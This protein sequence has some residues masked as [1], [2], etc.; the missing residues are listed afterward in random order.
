V[1]S[2][3]F[4][5][6]FSA[7]TGHKPYDYQRRLAGGD[8]GRTAESLL[9]SIPTGLGKTA[10]VVLAWLWNRVALL[11]QAEHGRWPRRLVYCLPMRTLVEQTRDNVAEWLARLAFAADAD[12]PRVKAA[13]E[14]LEE[15]ARKR[16]LADEGKLR[17]LKQDLLTAREDLIWLLEHSPVVLMGGEEIDARK[18]EWDI[19]PERPAILIGTQDM[20]LSRALNRGYAMNRYRW[21]MQFG[22]LNNDCLWV[23]DEIQLMGPGL[24][25]G[26]QLEAFREALGGFAAPTDAR[27]PTA[28][29]SWYASATASRELVI[30]RDWRSADGDK[31]PPSDEFVVQ[32]GVADLGDRNGSLGRRRLAMKAVEV[33]DGWYFDDGE[34]PRRIVNEH[35]RMLAETA[36]AT[37]VRR[38][39]LVVC[40]TVRKART[41]F[42]ALDKELAGVSDRPELLLLHSRFRRE[43][44][45]AIFKRIENP[46]DNPMGQIVVATQVIEA[47]VDISSAALWTEA[48]PLPSIVQRFGRLNRAGEFGHDGKLETGWTPRAVVVGVG[49]KLAPAGRREKAD[50]A[51]KR[52]KENAT[53]FRPYERSEC[54]SSLV[55]LS[56]L[57]DVGPG[58]LEA[59]LAQPLKDALKPPV[60]V[61]QLHELLDFFDSDANLSLGYT[62]VTPFVRGL[63]PNADVQVLWRN[64][65]TEAPPFSGDIDAGELCAVPLWEVLQLR[66]WRQGFVWQGRERGWQAASERNVF[67]GAVLLLP[68]SA[69]GYSPEKGWTGRPQDN[70]VANL[71]RTPTVPSDAELLSVLDDRWKSIGGHTEE[72]KAVLENILGSIRIR[73]D[74]GTG[75]AILDAM[76]WHDFGK[77]H[78]EWQG[79]VLQAAKQAGIAPETNQRPF[80]KFSLAGSPFLAGKSGEEL[81]AEIYRL[82]RSFRPGLRHEVASALALRQHHIEER[83][84]HGIMDLLAEYL[85]MSHHGRIRKVLRDELPK[86]PKAGGTVREEVCGIANGTQIAL[87]KVGNQ[88]LNAGPLSIECRK[89]GRCSDGLEGWTKGVLRLLEEFGPFRLAYL[90]ALFRAAD[91]R[92]SID[93]GD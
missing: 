77:N 86:S 72:A 14:H 88:I 24:G 20:L 50:D 12:D 51:E 7:G 25:T 4:D 22:L 9:I 5:T 87:V 6:F 76:D 64:W 8:Q 83:P 46:S 71:Y 78:P 59:A 70:S 2:I 26:C 73:T 41:L 38:R 48:A 69:G 27:V 61:V 42:D 43:D 17:R 33:H 79:A 36:D 35:Q 75:S 63:D 34:T 56:N 74:G 37:D 55:A 45:A 28:N 29:A 82:K 85:V 16:L 18:A 31:R 90:E 1:V 47:G 54:E 30:S 80:A 92:A 15:K 67:E 52:E 11:D 81:R 10:A 3:D 93:P 68:S 84:T 65:E 53:F 32:L 49:I 40:N 58:N 39:T 89:L 91:W 60:G 44:R 19:Y 21:P 23:M 66:T 57:D 62:D 13:V